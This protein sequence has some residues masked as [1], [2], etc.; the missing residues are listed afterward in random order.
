[1][2]A[3]Q[4]SLRTKVGVVA[5][6]AAL[7]LI[8]LYVGSPGERFKSSEEGVCRDKCTGLQKSSRLVPQNPKG[9]VSQGK[10][11]GPWSCECY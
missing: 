11:E 5:A 7:G 4:L 9:M 1:M 6:L 2:P 8:W 10:Y 3:P